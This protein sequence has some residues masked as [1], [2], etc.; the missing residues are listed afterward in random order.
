MK[1]CR[2]ENESRHL[3]HLQLQHIPGLLLKTSL[4]NSALLPR[5]FAR[6]LFSSSSHACESMLRDWSVSWR[7]HMD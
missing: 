6:M 7:E 3:S 2:R 4:A 5:F 1:G